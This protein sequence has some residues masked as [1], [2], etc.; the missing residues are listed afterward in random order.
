[1]TEVIVVEN[2][3]VH[4]NLGEPASIIGWATVYRDMEAKTTRL[5]IR[6]GEKGSELLD[7]FQEVAEIMAIGFAGMMRKPQDGG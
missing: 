6:M 1:M 7:Q 5:E 4:L 2:V 3:P